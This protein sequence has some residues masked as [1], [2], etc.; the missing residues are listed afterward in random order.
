MIRNTKEGKHQSPIENKLQL[1]VQSWNPWKN[2]TSKIEEIIYYIDE[3]VRWKNL[4][5]PNLYLTFILSATL[6]CRDLKDV[7]LEFLSQQKD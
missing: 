1:H 3:M 5:L 7:S 2:S 4:F 6:T